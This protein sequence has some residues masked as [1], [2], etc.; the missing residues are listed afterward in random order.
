M[1]NFTKTKKSGKD[2]T[3]LQNKTSPTSKR[4]AVLWEKAAHVQ[5]PSQ[6]QFLVL[7]LDGLGIT[8]VRD[9]PVTFFPPHKKDFP[10]SR[11]RYIGSGLGTG[12]FKSTEHWIP[13][14]GSLQKLNLEGSWL[15]A[16]HLDDAEFSHR[17]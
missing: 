11:T 2:H 15:P 5:P 10:R 14:I 16:W 8:S 17:V 4:T 6:I 12:K 13:N 7:V 3:R 9:G 1:W